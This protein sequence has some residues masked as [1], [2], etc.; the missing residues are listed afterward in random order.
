MCGSKSSECQ[1][2]K[3]RFF[4]QMWYLCILIAA[5]FC[6]FSA[7]QLTHNSLYSLPERTP[8]IRIEIRVNADTSKRDTFFDPVHQFAWRPLYIKVTNLSQSLIYL[9]QPGPETV[10]IQCEP[11]EW[12]PYRIRIGRSGDTALLSDVW[13]LDFGR[14]HRSEVVALVGLE[15]A[16][17]K[18]SSASFVSKGIQACTSTM[19]ADSG[20]YWIVAELE[21]LRNDNGTSDGWSGHVFSDTLWLTARELC[22]PFRK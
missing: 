1:R 10:S 3:E 11:N 20:K 8:T 21:Y 22:I 2:Q 16:N 12:V 6:S 4:R 14:I 5:E 13:I 17:D 9:P 7:G 18:E 15:P 19:P